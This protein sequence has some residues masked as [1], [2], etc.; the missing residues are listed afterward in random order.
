MDVYY[1]DLWLAE[2]LHHELWISSQEGG[3]L[4]CLGRSIWLTLLLTSLLLEFLNRY[5]LILNLYLL[6]N[7]H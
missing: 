4:L 3:N 2:C 1:L 6:F 7:H 5:L